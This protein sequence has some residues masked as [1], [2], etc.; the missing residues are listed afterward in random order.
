MTDETLEVIVIAELKTKD[1]V[2]AEVDKA[3]SE[4][5]EWVKDN[6]QGTL[7]YSAHRSKKD[8]TKIIF[9]EAYRRQD[10]LD[11]HMQSSGFKDFGRHIVQYIDPSATKIEQF[12]LIA[13]LTGLEDRTPE[14]MP[15]EVPP[16]D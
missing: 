6:E 7:I 4:W 16:R 3:I 8:P 11:G 13:G 9:Y 1:G 2:E 5:I 15:T 14:N 12:S 10:A